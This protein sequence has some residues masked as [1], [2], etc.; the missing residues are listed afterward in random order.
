MRSNS[1]QGDSDT[2]V[3]LGKDKTKYPNHRH[4]HFNNQETQTLTIKHEKRAI[5]MAG[6][7][8]KHRR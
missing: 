2:L 1:G 6:W 5:K 3:V 8:R 4:P 7:E